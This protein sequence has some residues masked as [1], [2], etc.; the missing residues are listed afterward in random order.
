MDISSWGDGFL[1]QDWLSLFFG[2]PNLQVSAS[3]DTQPK[4]LAGA[5][6]F[7]MFRNS[8]FNS[9]L[10]WDL[11]NVTSLKYMFSQTP[12]NQPINFRNS[13]EVRSTASMFEDTPFFN[14]PFHFDAS[15]LTDTNFMFANAVS[16]NQLIT[17]D[18]SSVTNMMGMFQAATNFNQPLNFNTSFVINMRG[19]FGG[20]TNF[21]QPLNFD[22]KSVTTMTGMFA[23]ATKFSQHVNFDTSQVTTLDLMFVG[24]SDFSS[25][26]TFTSTAQ[27]TDARSM[28]RDVNGFTQDLS[29]WDTQNVMLC[30]EFCDWC[31][32]PAFPSCS[33]CTTIYTVGVIVR[34]P[35]SPPLLLPRARLQEP[36][37]LLL[38]RTPRRGTHTHTRA[39]RKGPHSQPSLPL[40]PHSPG[41][42][43]WCCL[44]WRDSKLNT[45]EGDI[46]S[47]HTHDL[48]P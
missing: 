24:A 41:G 48:L 2:Y 39:R 8:S 9:P 32:L 33:P 17:W 42:R 34:V 47:I 15:G 26:V 16:F 21:N 36:L 25:T 30:D 38:Q 18:T 35:P 1:V 43:C 40:P 37:H 7:N 27:V 10:N 28:F 3:P 11:T 13:Q 31:G 23:H 46:K 29:G 4:F 14:Q 5:S 19:M 12:L 20:A 45:F 6:L 44:W 22:T